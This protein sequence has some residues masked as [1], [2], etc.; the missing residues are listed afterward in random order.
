MIR[1]FIL[2]QQT[3]GGSSKPCVYP[4]PQRKLLICYVPLRIWEG[5]SERS[6]G[7]GVLCEKS[8]GQRARQKRLRLHWMCRWCVRLRSHKQTTFPPSGLYAT[9]GEGISERETNCN[10]VI[11]GSAKLRTWKKAPLDPGVPPLLSPSLLHVE[12]G[13]V[14]GWRYNPEQRSLEARNERAETSF[15]ITFETGPNASLRPTIV[16]WLLIFLD[17][18]FRPKREQEEGQKKAHGDTQVGGYNV[19]SK[20]TTGK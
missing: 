9:D 12:C 11:A 18:A 5:G 14:W 10:I 7:L 2:I 3:V 6:E 1:L 4:P 19:S 8:A 20:P 15:A 16:H 17:E 13:A